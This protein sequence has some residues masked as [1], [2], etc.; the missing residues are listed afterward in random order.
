MELS[1][2]VLDER[3]AGAADRVALIAGV[4]S[5]LRDIDT[6]VALPLDGPRL[7]AMIPRGASRNIFAL[8]A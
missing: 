4:G 6:G 3:S 5:A 2:Y 8:A 7:E 1:R